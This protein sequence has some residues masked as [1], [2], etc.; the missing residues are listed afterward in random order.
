MGIGFDFSVGPNGDVF[1]IQRVDSGTGTTQVHI[2]SAA[3]GY[4]NFSKQTGTALQETP[5]GLT[6]PI[7][8]RKHRCTA[9]TTKLL[10]RL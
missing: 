6:L 1:A 5:S 2:L 10:Q 4:Q 9:C 7:D 3:S 8:A